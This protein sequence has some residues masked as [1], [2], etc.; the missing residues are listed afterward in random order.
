MRVNLKGVCV[1]TITKNGPAD[2]AGIQGSTIDQYS[3]KHL[4]DIIIAL[5]GLNRN[6][7]FD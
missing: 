7:L 3:K 6:H 5:D 2:K 4:G 1:N